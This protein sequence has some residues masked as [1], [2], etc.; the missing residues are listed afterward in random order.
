MEIQTLTEKDIPLVA[1]LQPDDWGDILPGFRMYT[2]ASHCYPVKIVINDTIVGIGATIVHHEVAWLGHI[3]V[4]PAFRGK[5]IGQLITQTLVDIAHRRQCETILL[6]ATELGAP[7][8]EKAGFSTDTEYLFFKDIHLQ[9]EAMSTGQLLPYTAAFKQSIEGIDGL[10]TAENRSFMLEAYLHSGW[11]Y[12]HNN[13]VQ[14]FYLPALG[15]GL[16]MAHTPAAGIDLL[17]LH[18]KNNDKAVFPKENITALNYLQA[19]G[20]EPFRTAKRMR[21][22]K[23]RPFKLENMY[24]RIAG[25][26]G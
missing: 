4:H 19:N 26:I 14:G 11:V 24:N 5:G 9:N 15:D 18:L 25:N 20:Y 2:S 6:I 16:I 21:L 1:A 22:G 13:Q 17:K 8:Y 3:I 23:N 12:C 10:I 7:V